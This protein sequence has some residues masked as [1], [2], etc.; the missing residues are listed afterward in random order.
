MANEPAAFLQGNL[1]RHITVMALTASIGLMAI[2]VVD[3]VDMIFISMLGKEELAAAVGYAG[4]ILFFTS[5]FGIGVAIAAGALVARALGEGDSHTASRRAATSLFYGVIFGAIF[6]AAVW[7]NVRPLAMLVGASGETLDMAVLYLQIIIPSLPLLIIGMVGGA[8]LRAHGDA[9]RA[10]IATILGGVVNAVLD[11]ILIFGFDLD[12]VGAAI[13][14]VAARVTIGAV[15]LY[16]IFRWHGGL[17]RPT[18]AEFR[19]DFPAIMA[20]ALPAIMTQFATPIGQAY[21]TRSMAQ[22]GAEAV[23]GMAIISRLVPVSFGVIFALSGAIGPVIGQNFGAGQY[24]RVRRAYADGL[25][26]T[27]IVVLVV[28]TLLYLLRAPIAD[29]FSATGQTRDLIF[30]FCGPLALA[31]VFNG[32][33]FVSNAVFNNLGHPYY[34]TWINWGRHTLGTI[35]FVILGAGWYQ[36]AGVLFGQAFGG[37][38]FAVI[39]VVLVL[40]VMRS[41]ETPA[42][43]PAYARQT[44][45]IQLSHNRR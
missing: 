16:P 34:S 4:A 19:V 14:S 43:A 15:A 2:F 42:K 32:V 33:L 1:M 21:V 10:M 12:L 35:P 36:G 40:R 44:R 28:T 41:K 13:A 7:F 25:V 6:A 11:P 38:V 29:L 18:A 27:L 5:S 24:G 22:F 20:I 26:F 8:I 37:L 31:W 3:L 17:E 30:L 9:R 39:A 23:A 45:L